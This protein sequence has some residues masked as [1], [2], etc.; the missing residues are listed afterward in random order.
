MTVK[1]RS[2]TLGTQITATSATARQV[3]YTASDGI[4][5][6][7]HATVFN[8]HASSAYDV[9]VYIKSDAT[10]SGTLQEIERVSVAANTTVT[11]SKLISHRVPSGGTIQIHD[12][13]GADMY[14]TMSGDSRT[15]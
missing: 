3:I 9:Y 11:L 12:D 4:T 2:L 8:S 10:T 7:N 14:V 6:I 15:Q 5:E 13:S 1:W